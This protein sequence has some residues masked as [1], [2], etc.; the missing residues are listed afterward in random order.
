MNLCHSTG[1]ATA[2][3]LL[4]ETDKAC[5][6]AETLPDEEKAV[7]ELRPLK[8]LFRN[9]VHHTAQRTSDLAWRESIGVVLSPPKQ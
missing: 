2:I 7:V 8:L 6:L 4:C 1:I 5:Q 3:V 9:L